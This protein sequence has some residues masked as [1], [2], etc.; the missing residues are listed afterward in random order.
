ME[1]RIIECKICI[2]EIILPSII[3]P[4]SILVSISQTRHTVFLCTVVAAVKLTAGFQPVSDDPTT[5]N[6]TRRS[7]RL[8]RTFEGIENMRF[9]VFDYVKTFIV[10]VATGFALAHGR[11]PCKKLS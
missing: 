1:G 2:R 5:A 10:V 6:F 4:K 3:L 11:V 7:Q 8:N 9:A